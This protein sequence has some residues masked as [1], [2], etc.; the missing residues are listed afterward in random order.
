MSQLLSAIILSQTEVRILSISHILPILMH[1][2]TFESEHS[3]QVAST[4]ANSILIL[5]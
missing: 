5:F 1:T 4:K 3:I 2:I